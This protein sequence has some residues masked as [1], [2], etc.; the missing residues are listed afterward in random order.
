MWVLSHR[1]LT[2]PFFFTKIYGHYNS[3]LSNN[4]HA[5][6]PLNPSGFI[7]GGCQV[8]PRPPASCGLNAKDICIK[9]LVAGICFHAYQQ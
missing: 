4:N 8:Y 3:V 5:I 6:V 2:I 7:N 1:F 9:A